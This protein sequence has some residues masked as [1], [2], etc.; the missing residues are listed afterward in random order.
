MRWNK[1]DHIWENLPYP[2]VLNR[3]RA[4]YSLRLAEKQVDGVCREIQDKEIARAETA[5]AKEMFE[6]KN[7]FECECEEPDCTICGDTE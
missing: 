7:D 5:L 4:M 6:P 1:A 3:I 2:E